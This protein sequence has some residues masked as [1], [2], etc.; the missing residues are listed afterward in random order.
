MHAS[1]SE[2]ASRV[3]TRKHVGRD[4]HALLNVGTV[5]CIPPRSPASKIGT[6][7]R[8]FQISGR[9]QRCKR[10]RHSLTD[11][12]RHAQRCTSSVWAAGHRQRKVY[13]R[14]RRMHVNAPS[15]DRARQQAGARQAH[16]PPTMHVNSAGIYRPWTSMRNNDA[17]A[18]EMTPT[19][20]TAEP[21]TRS[22]DPALF[23][24]VTLFPLYYRS[25]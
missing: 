1:V 13:A 7:C 4:C 6:G 15:A 12:L 9:H 8:P 19:V 17:R 11:R 22:P 14:Q 2:L 23:V 24:T 5:Q 3:N 18:A 21:P 20:K 10:L 16:R 25:Q